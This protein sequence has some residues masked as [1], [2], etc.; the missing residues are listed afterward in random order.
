MLPGYKKKVVLLTTASCLVYGL[1]R[2]CFPHVPKQYTACLNVLACVGLAVSVGLLYCA[3]ALLGE[4]QAGKAW[5]LAILAFGPFAAVMLPSGR[6]QE[7]KA[8]N[9]YITNSGEAND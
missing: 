1:M 9:R 8:K 2:V 7:K 5:R 4:A 6:P 3:W